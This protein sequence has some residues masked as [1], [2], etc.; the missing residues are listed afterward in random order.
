MISSPGLWYILKLRSDFF[1]EI[2]MEGYE[3]DVEQFGSDVEKMEDFMPSV[4]KGGGG[5]A[6]FEANR[7]Y[8]ATFE[9]LATSKG[10]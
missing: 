3:P 10:D 9:V 5:L 7:V 2:G 4:T 1:S 6:H 8:P